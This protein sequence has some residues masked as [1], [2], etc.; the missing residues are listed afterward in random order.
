VGLKYAGDYHQLTVYNDPKFCKFTGLDPCYPNYKVRVPALKYQSRWDWCRANEID[1]QLAEETDGEGR[2]F[3]IFE[4]VTRWHAESFA[5]HFEV[6]DQRQL[7]VEKSMG[8]IEYLP[9]PWQYQ[10]TLPIAQRRHKGSE[11]P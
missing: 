6:L 4:F 10:N 5:A 9:P 2:I 11:S 1:A 8:Q 7:W 3:Y